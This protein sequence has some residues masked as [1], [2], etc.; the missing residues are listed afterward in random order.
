MQR[1]AVLAVIT[2]VA[3]RPTG[4]DR[5]TFAAPRVRAD[6]TTAGDGVP[7]RTAP[8]APRPDASTTPVASGP[9]CATDD[10][11]RVPG[12]R[13][14]C[15]N[16]GLA[17]QYTQAFRDCAEGRAWREAHAVGTCV[18][19]DCRD[20]ASTGDT[21]GPGQRCGT[22]EMVQFPQRVCL[23]AACTA[24]RQCRRAALGHCAS[25]LAAGHCTRGGWACSYPHDRCAPRDPVRMCPVHPGMWTFCAPRIGRFACVDE[26]VT[27]PP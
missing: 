17:A 14:R 15:F 25:Y 23:A 12:R 10:D 4:T 6:G 22:L 19:D 20:D 16:A 8:P 27:V 11:C 13:G 9:P 24:D 1:L 21:C 26:P 7:A 18:F 3:C 2:A 5:R